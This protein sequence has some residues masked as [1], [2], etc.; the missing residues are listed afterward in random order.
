MEVKLCVKKIYCPKCQRL[1]KCQEQTTNNTL[2]IL[3]SRCGSPIW[4]KDGVTWKYVK[5]GA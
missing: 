1:V 5:A 4:V 3:C 2:R